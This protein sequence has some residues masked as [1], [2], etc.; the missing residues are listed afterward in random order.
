[1]P[2]IREPK[3]STALFQRIIAWEHDQLS[4]SETLQ[5]FQELVVCGLAWNSTGAVRRTAALLIQDGRINNPEV[6][7]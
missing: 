3:Y 4:H 1:M 2:E 5:L 7:T 6:T